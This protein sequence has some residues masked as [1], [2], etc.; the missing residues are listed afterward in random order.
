MTE[1]RIAVCFFVDLA[2]SNFK[3]NQIAIDFVFRAGSLTKWL[4]GKIPCI[5]ITRHC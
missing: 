5:S 3:K 2:K 4:G 1:I